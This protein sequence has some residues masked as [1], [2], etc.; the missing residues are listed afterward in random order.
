MG[1]LDVLKLSVTSTALAGGGGANVSWAPSSASL[2]A[3]GRAGY[4]GAALGY[5][6]QEWNWN[7][8]WLGWYG[9]R[10]AA[11]NDVGFSVNFGSVELPA[12]GTRRAIPV[13]RPCI[14]HPRV[15]CARRARGPTPRAPQP[16]RCSA[17]ACRESV[18]SSRCAAAAASPRRTG[19]G[20]G[21]H[22]GHHTGPRGP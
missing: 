4:G 11:T 15:L 6:L 16:A 5:V 2:A 8:P 9:N 21:A 12:C 20:G 19:G 10:Q 14:P 13:T 18:F 1:F 22:V 3:L 17:Q 7:Q